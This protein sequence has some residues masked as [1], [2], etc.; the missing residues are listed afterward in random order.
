MRHFLVAALSFFLAACGFTPLYAT[1]SGAG[2]ITVEEIDGRA[3]FALRKALLQRLAIGVPGID[4]AAQLT[5]DL[6]TDFERL[7]LQPDESAARTDVTARAQYVLNMGDRVISGRVRSTTSYQ[8]PDQPFADIP[9]QVDAEERA[10]TLLAQRIVD[11]LR[12]KA[13]TMP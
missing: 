4:E 9:A 10:M 5:V 1:G 3:G 6:S 7:T 8:A 12:L 11:D 13:A 2:D